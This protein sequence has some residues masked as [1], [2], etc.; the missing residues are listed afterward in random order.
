MRIINVHKT[1][2]DRNVTITFGF[3]APDQ[4][5]DDADP[6]PLPD[7]E[8]TELAEDTFFGYVDEYHPK[9]P[10]EIVVEMPKN[11][12]PGMETL[13]PT[14]IQHHFSRRVTGLEHEMRLFKNEGTY[15]TI[16]TIITAI[17][18]MSF[19]VLYRTGNITETWYTFVIAFM[20]LIANWATMWH[21]IEM[22]LYDYRNLRRKIQLY[23]KIAGIPISV[24]MYSSEPE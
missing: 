5:F 22:Y 8:L 15:S 7:K 2:R 21:T 24:R 20:L 11:D 4:L 17:I 9:K 1:E 23:R 14:A 12:L 13:I 18:G 16:I 3:S 6:H 19:I 10:L